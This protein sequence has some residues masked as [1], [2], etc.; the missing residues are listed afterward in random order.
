MSVAQLLFL[1]C[2]LV[3]VSLAEDADSLRRQ[4]HAGTVTAVTA[5]GQKFIQV[6]T[7]ESFKPGGQVECE[8]CINFMNQAV[9]ALIQIIAQGGIGGGCS[10]VCGELPESWMAQI[11]FLLCEFEGIEY[12]NELLQDADPDPIWLC[13]ELDACPSS[14]NSTGVVKRIAIQPKA[15]PQGSTFK[16]TFTYQLNSVTGTGQQLIAVVPPPG[17]E[18]E[19]FG[20]EGTIISQEPGIYT[21]E[22]SFEAQPTQENPFTPGLYQVYCEVCE[23]SCGD[24]HKDTYVILQGMSTF[25]ITN[26]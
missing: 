17:P 23:G 2:S 19:P 25:N 1:V 16:I 8:V 18:A 5:M 14:D 4:P 10:A 24:T 7:K 22:A 26:Q 9:S 6:R 3:F 11:C 15:A 21:L 13:M 20:W 12:F